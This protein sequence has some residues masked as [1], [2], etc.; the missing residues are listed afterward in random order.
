MGEQDRRDFLKRLAK[1]AAYAAPVVHSLAA[2]ADVL[3]Q[4][5]TE[6]HPKSSG[7]DQQQ[8]T[9]TNEPGR[10]APWDRRP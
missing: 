1:A 2:P 8:P 7:F 9:T 6:H 10:E 5:W 4:A 3:G